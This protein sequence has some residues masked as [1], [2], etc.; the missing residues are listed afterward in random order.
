MLDKDGLS[1]GVDIKGSPLGVAAI[2]GVVH[3]VFPLCGYLV[4][5]NTWC[6][7][8]EGTLL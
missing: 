7:V 2:D 8:F 1:F 4:I 3:C 6:V 5:Y